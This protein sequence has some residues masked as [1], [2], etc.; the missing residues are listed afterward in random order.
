MFSIREGIYLHC[1]GHV[2]SSKS[3]TVHTHR[4]RCLLT[5]FGRL[6]VIIDFGDHPR[7]EING[8]RREVQ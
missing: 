7:R 4:L 5:M 1:T 6:A 8:L 2:A 3:C